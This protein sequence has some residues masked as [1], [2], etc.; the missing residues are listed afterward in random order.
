MPV[1]L[2]EDE[3]RGRHG[4]AEEAEEAD[5]ERIRRDVCVRLAD[6]PSVDPSNMD[7]QVAAGEVT[8]EGTVDS[9]DE[10]RRAEEIARAVRGVASVRNLLGY[11]T[12]EGGRTSG[13]APGMAGEAPRRPARTREQA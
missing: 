13:T 8:L 12:A 3:L 4:G 9:R 1:R 7:V 6:N 11:E 10:R 5:D 2:R